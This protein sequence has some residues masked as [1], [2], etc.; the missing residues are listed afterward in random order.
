MIANFAVATFM[1]S[2]FP[3]GAALIITHK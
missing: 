3:P 2:R 1:V